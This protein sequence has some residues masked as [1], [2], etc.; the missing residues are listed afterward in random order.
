[1]REETVAES[2]NSDA[3]RYTTRRHFFQNCGIGLGAMAL[4]SLLQEGG[5]SAASLP[6][7]MHPMAPRPPSRPALVV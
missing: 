2:M 1:M 3:L 7:A 4:A 5:A 6:E